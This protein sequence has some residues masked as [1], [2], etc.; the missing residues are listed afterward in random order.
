MA[1]PREERE[2]QGRRRKAAGYLAPQG[3][4]FNCASCDWFKPERVSIVPE[5]VPDRVGIG[6]CEQPQVRAQ[7]QGLGCCNLWERNGISS[8]GA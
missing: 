4:P 1:N 8:P 3:V 5:P 2:I 7:V 6:F